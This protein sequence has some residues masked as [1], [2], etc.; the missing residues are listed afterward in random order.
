ML[1]YRTLIHYTF[2]TI[3]KLR[4]YRNRIA[5]GRAGKSPARTRA[6]TKH[7]LLLPVDRNP[8]FSNIP[9]NTRIGHNLEMDR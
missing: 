1:H 8:E 2:R 7:P 4:D 6:G 9:R 3:S 5:T